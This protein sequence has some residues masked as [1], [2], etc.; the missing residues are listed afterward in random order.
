M[1]S[2][3]KKIPDASLVFRDLLVNH[4]YDDPSE[5]YHYENG[6]GEESGE[7]VATGFL[8][9]VFE[10]FLF[11]HFISPVLSVVEKGLHCNCY[12]VTTGGSNGRGHRV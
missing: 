4:L 6:E 2:T 8:R 5:W 3:I 10:Q 12:G 7:V 11:G 9:I 1:P